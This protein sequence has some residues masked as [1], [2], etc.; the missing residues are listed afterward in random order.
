M[1]DVLRHQKELVPVLEE[2]IELIDEKIKTYEQGILEQNIEESTH[3]LL[4]WK[5]KKQETN[6]EPKT[7]LMTST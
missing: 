5:E 4:S 6:Q 2:N 1:E 3:Q 7:S